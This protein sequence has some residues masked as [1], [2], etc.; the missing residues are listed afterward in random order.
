[1]HVKH[2]SL[3][4]HAFIIYLRFTIKLPNLNLASWANC[5][6][7]RIRGFVQQPNSQISLRK[8]GMCG[9]QTCKSWDLILILKMS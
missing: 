7:N 2:L 5:N 6:I 8:E 3:Y 4:Q 1:M 9:V